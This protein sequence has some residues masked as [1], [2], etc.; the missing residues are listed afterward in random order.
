MVF[1]EK[2][3]LLFWGEKIKKFEIFTLHFGIN[4]QEYPDGET[5]LIILDHK[6][7]Q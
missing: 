3:L 7:G 5:E 4:Y 2:L 1:V 6:Q